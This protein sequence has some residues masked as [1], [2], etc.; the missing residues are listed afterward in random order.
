MRINQCIQGTNNEF[1]GSFWITE[2]T[3]MQI[4]TNSR[5]KSKYQIFSASSWQDRKHI[6]T[7]DEIPQQVSILESPKSRIYCVLYCANLLAQIH[8]LPPP[9]FISVALLALLTGFVAT[10]VHYRRSTNEIGCYIVFT[11]KG[12]VLTTKT[13][14]RPCS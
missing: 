4:Q 11:R 14:Q 5:H 6:L 9:V 1:D 10:G 8:S 7:L 12:L 13:N 2:T 3:I